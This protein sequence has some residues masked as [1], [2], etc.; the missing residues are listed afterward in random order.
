MIKEDS[1]SSPFY[2]LTKC[3]GISEQIADLLDAEIHKPGKISD[4]FRKRTIAP[5]DPKLADELQHVH[6]KLQEALEIL[7]AAVSSREH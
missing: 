6:S 5:Q 4:M 7:T 1:E 2:W 3:E